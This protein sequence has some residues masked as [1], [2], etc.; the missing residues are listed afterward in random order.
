VATVDP[1]FV[2]ARGKVLDRGQQQLVGFVVAHSRRWLGRGQ[3][4][5]AVPVACGVPANSAVN[6]DA[7]ERGSVQRRRGSIRCASRVVVPAGAGHLQRWDS[8]PHVIAS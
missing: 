7:R 4:Q 2:V 3:R 6:A 1:S 8:A 5:G